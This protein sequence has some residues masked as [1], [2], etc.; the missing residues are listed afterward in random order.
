MMRKIV[1]KENVFGGNGVIL[2]EY[3]LNEE[4]LNNM[5][6][7]YAKVTLMPGSS[8]GYH[9]HNGESETY[10]ILSGTGTYINTKKEETEVLPGD[11]TFTASGEGHGI[12]N[13][14]SEK[15]VLMA[16]IIYDEKRVQS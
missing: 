8:L 14:G 3:L 1:K 7:L 5:C 13:T 9:E 6:R 11:V 2:F 4:Q 12:I 10:Y 16:L 15:L